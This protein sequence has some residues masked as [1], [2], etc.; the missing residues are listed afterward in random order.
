MNYVE[1]LVDNVSLY[2]DVNLATLS[3]AIDIIVVQQKDGQ[4]NSSPFH[5]RF[6]KL[7][8]LR[9]RQKYVRISVNGQPVDLKMKLGEAGEAFFVEEKD[10]DVPEYLCTSPLQSPLFSPISHPSSPS[11]LASSPVPD[12]P[13]STKSFH[14][15]KSTTSP[16]FT[17][18]TTFTA[19]KEAAP[20]EQMLLTSYLTAKITE[21]KKEL[22]GELTSPLHI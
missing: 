4:F 14:L 20:Q 6:G 11:S 12:G 16:A 10:D 8:C 5:V 18:S 22:A 2:F 17:K 7:M 13:C 21:Q 3:G 15:Q 1:K 9:T 19:T